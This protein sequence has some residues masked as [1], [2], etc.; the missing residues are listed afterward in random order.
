MSGSLV[1]TIDSVN[2]AVVYHKSSHIIP[3][4]LQKR[5]LNQ[6]RFPFLKFWLLAQS[7]E[8]WA[9]ILSFFIHICIEFSKILISWMQTIAHQP[10]HWTDADPRSTRPVLHFNLKRSFVYIKYVLWKWNFIWIGLWFDAKYFIRFYKKKTLDS[11]HS[12]KILI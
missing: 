12:Q 6:A 1:A 11:V 5:S 2:G 7:S 4:S 8:G 3:T 10:S 9:S